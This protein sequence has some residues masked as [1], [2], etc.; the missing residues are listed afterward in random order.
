MEIP[1]IFFTVVRAPAKVNL[2]LRI[3]GRRPDGYHLLQLLNCSIGLHDEIAVRIEP[4]PRAIQLSIVNTECEG[5]ELV[6][7]EP[8]L[9]LAGLAALT[10][11]NEADIDAHVSLRLT[12]NIPVGGGLGGG[13]SDAAAVLRTVYTWAAA[14]QTTARPIDLG[15]IALSLGADVPYLLEGGLA[16][17]QG[18]G[19]NVVPLCSTELDRRPLFLVIPS[20]RVA[21]AAA[22]SRFRALGTPFSVPL[23]YSSENDLVYRDLF[24]AL[25][26]DL[27]VPSGQLCPAVPHIL[28][29]L[30]EGRDWSAGMTGSGSTIMVLPRIGVPTAGI[31]RRL[32]KVLPGSCRIV[33]TC[34]DTIRMEPSVASRP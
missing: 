25:H 34:F 14:R 31:H 11:L 5:V 32:Q 23:E 33:E 9:N 8:Q 12:K 26:N 7:A 17:V 24:G 30:R 4:G 3:T 22:F 20:G 10:L 29:V 13:S 2:A 19:E 28:S 27:E 1:D 21:T 15:A 6:P 18:I 16:F